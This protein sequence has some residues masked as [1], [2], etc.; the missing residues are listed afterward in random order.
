MTA[1]ARTTDTDTA[2]HKLFAAGKPAAISS[3]GKNR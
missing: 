2:A 3:V 1:T